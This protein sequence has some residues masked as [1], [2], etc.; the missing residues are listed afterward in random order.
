M[1]ED[2]VV[3]SRRARTVAATRDGDRSCWA[4]VRYSL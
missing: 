1:T 3:S 2:A 4:S